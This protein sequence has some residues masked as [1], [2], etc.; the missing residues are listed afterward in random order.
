[1]CSSDLEAFEERLY[2]YELTIEKLNKAVSDTQTKQDE[3]VSLLKDVKAF[4]DD[5]KAKKRWVL[6]G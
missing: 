3:I 5:A 1:M 4:I 2:Q 6:F